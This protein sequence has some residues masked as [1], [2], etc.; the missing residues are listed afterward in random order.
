MGEHKAFG[1]SWHRMVRLWSGVVLAGLMLSGTP[2]VAEVEI[3]VAT[4]PGT[5][6]GLSVGSQCRLCVDAYWGG[7]LLGR[8]LRP[9]CNSGRA[10]RAI[11]RS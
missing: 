11:S 10:A 9:R 7:R 4:P 8:E 1:V 2:L 3:F 5:F 6:T